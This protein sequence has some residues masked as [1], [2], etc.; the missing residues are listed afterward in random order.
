[1]S[2]T[3]LSSNFIQCV[4]LS[5]ELPMCHSASAGRYWRKYTRTPSA[6]RYVIDLSRKVCSLEKKKFVHNLLKVWTGFSTELSKRSCW[7]SSCKFSERITEGAGF[8]K[9]RTM[10]WGLK[11]HK[12]RKTFMAPWGALR[13]AVYVAAV[14]S[15][16][17]HREIKLYFWHQKK[18]CIQCKGGTNVKCTTASEHWCTMPIFHC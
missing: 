9:T 6:R 8:E 12:L 7:L 5:K 17:P 16:S 15:V 14:S 10:H 13:Q 2:N 3:G 11:P 18:I 4:N 1:M